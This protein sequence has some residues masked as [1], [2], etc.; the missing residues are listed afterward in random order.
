MNS[1]TYRITGPQSIARLEPLLSQ[2]GSDINWVSIDASGEVTPTVPIDLVWETS[3]EKTWRD[4]HNSAIIFNRL[5]NS[6]IFEDKSNF[7]FLQLRMA[8]PTLNSHIAP[9]KATLTRWCQLKWKS[10]NQ[11]LQHD[12]ES[13]DVDMNIESLAPLSFL[14][15]G[16][17]WGLPPS[18]ATSKDWWALKASKGNGGKDVWIINRDNFENILAKLPSSEEFVIQR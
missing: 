15:E 12:I 17:G 11:S 7:A 3:C 18:S 5:H 16:H 14:G 10:D 9:D 4:T 13:I 2:C 1:K 6:Q 8:C